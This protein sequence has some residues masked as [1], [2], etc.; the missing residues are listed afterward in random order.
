MKT[1]NSVSYY[2]FMEGVTE[3]NPVSEL[4]NKSGLRASFVS[5]SSYW[6]LL[7]IGIF[8]KTGDVFFIVFS[9]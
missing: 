1:V 6:K 3:R 7:V 8:L 5:S 2:C 9:P 4:L